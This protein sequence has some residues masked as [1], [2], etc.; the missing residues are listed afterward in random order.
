MGNMSDSCSND[1][2]GVNAVAKFSPCPKLSFFI[3]DARKKNMPD[4]VE[5]LHRSNQ[6]NNNVLIV[7][8][9]STK[10]N[11]NE[12]PPFEKNG[13]WTT[14]RTK[15]LEIQIYDVHERDHNYKSETIDEKIISVYLDENF[16]LFLIEKSEV[17]GID[18]PQFNFNEMKFVQFPRI[19]Y[20]NGKCTPFTN[21]IAESIY[22]IIDGKHA[23]NS[24]LV[25][26]YPFVN[27]S[28]H[29]NHFCV[30]KKAKPPGKP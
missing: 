20:E 8:I 28:V 7:F 21:T 15:N 22:G 18:M 13:R 4:F 29:Y 23:T 5:V 6:T 2:C 30:D 1:S 26:K 24:E 11:E 17:V 12:L 14:F 3:V 10:A 19:L 27:I 16:K 25:K 9:C